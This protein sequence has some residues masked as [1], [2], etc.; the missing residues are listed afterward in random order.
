MSLPHNSVHVSESL[1]TRWQ[2][3]Y[4]S[5]LNG[6]FSFAGHGG[7]LRW[8]LHLYLTFTFRDAVIGCAATYFMLSVY[9]KARRNP[10]Q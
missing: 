3:C 2:T 7:E 8:P 9:L 5:Q 4:R 6:P 10:L 1:L